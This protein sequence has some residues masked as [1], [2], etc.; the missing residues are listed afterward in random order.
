[1]MPISDGQLGHLRN[2]VD[3][4][5]LSGTRYELKEQVARGGMGTVYR[6]HDAQLDR[7]VALIV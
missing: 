1:M 2:L 7:N 6:A 4:P 5:D 3:W